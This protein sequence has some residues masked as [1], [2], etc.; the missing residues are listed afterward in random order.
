MSIGCKVCKSPDVAEINMELA[1]GYS[2]SAVG[3]AYGLEP[4]T[5]RKHWKEHVLS[6]STGLQGQGEML[7][8]LRDVLDIPLQMRERKQLIDALI[9]RCIEPL[10]RKPTKA[11]PNAGI[12]AVPQGFL[13]G[14]LR[15]QQTDEQ[16][17]LKIT[18]VMKEGV[19]DMSAG[20]VLS[21]QYGQIK[22]AIEGRLDEISHGDSETAAQAKLLLAEMLAPMDEI[23]AEY[24]DL[25]P[26]NNGNGKHKPN[27]NGR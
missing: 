26:T 7:I 23:D 16:T 20:A 4:H 22:N 17:I 2:S 1:Q 19:I 15:I 8:T 3:V 14:L 11:H 9:E 24:R 5:I 27:T 6:T 13:L 18:G 25:G 10:S 12:D 21:T